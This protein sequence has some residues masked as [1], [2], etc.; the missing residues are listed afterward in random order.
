VPLLV[1]ESTTRFAQAAYEADVDMLVWWGSEMECVSA[2]AR[3]ERGD[4]LSPP[5]IARAL[6][7]LDAI[8]GA[9]TEVEPAQVIRETARRLLRVHDLRAGDAVQLAAALTAAEGHPSRLPIVS[10]DRRLLD[11]AD[12]EGFPLVELG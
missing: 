7:R 5:S 3:L 4:G 2:L 10:V 1:E 8:G 9:W 11:A 6:D 12:R